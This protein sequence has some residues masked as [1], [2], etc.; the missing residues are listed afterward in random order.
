MNRAAPKTS[1]ILNVLL[2]EDDPMVTD[3]GRRAAAGSNRPL[4]LTVL[5][6][7]DAVLD[8][9]ASLTAEHLPHIILLNLKLPKLDGLAVLRT[10]RSNVAT[11]DT[12]IVVFST[13]YTQEDVLMAYQVG[14]NTFVAKPASEEEFAAFLEQNLSY[15]LEPRQ[16][17]QATG[18]R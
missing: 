15:W 1:Q 17:E 14:A 13:E 16:V 3:W 9:L 12:P 6:V 11:C 7:G 4:E 8:W 18:A 2:V 10:L 5:P